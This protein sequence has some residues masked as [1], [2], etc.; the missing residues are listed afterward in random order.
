LG[1]SGRAIAVRYKEHIRYI[2]TNALASA[3]A[4]HTLN[5]Q[6]EYGCLN[7][8]LQLLKTCNKG[9]LMNLWEIFYIQQLSQMGKLVPEQQPQEPNSLY[10][11]GSLP[12]QFAI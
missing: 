6:H 12:S 4:L 8:T 1:Q 2:R 9:N 10:A 5:Q 3:Y 7:E 11:L